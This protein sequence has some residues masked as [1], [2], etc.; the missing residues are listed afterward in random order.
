MLLMMFLQ[1]MTPTANLPA[2]PV[3]PLGVIGADKPCASTN[4]NDIIVCGR[5]DINQRYRLP[6]LDTD[7]FEP[8]RR[9][10]TSLIGNVRGAAEVE[11]KEI[12]PGITSNRVMF[13]LKL[14]F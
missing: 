4:S 8:N 1:N 10:E 13:R 5:R 6:Q 7:R 2:P 14:P 11:S 12:G 3:L 9:A